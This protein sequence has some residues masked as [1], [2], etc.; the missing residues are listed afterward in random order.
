MINERV[1]GVAQ[2]KT[3]SNDHVALLEAE[4]ASTAVG[5]E[6]QEIQNGYGACDLCECTGYR[7]AHPNGTCVCGHW[8]GSHS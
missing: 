7:E 4:H 8:I 1:I 5:E 6:F 2:G 3:V